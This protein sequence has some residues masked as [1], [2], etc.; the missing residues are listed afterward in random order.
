MK[1]G[2]NI[3]VALDMV[4]LA[5]P[6]TDIIGITDL[7]GTTDYIDTETNG[8][9]NYTEYGSTPMRINSVISTA[10]YV[11]LTNAGLLTSGQDID[12][13]ANGLIS[14]FITVVLEVGDNFTSGIGSMITAGTSITVNLDYLLGD[15]VGSIANISGSISSPLTFINGGPN[16]D[17][18][19]FNYADG[20]NT[21]GTS[22]ASAPA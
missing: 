12:L 19:N 8:F 3:I 4:D 21:Q 14:A 2:G 20:V 11:L 9:I 1:A 7:T 5:G 15:L 18:V 6:E 10:N 16:N 17:A 13:L 22:V